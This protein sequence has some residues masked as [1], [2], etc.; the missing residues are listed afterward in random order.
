[1]LVTEPEFV[2]VPMPDSEGP[3]YGGQFSRIR[4]REKV[5]M[6]EEPVQL[7][8]TGR[9]TSVFPPPRAARVNCPVTGRCAPRVLEAELGSEL[10]TGGLDP[11]SSS[12][13]DSLVTADCFPAQL[14]LK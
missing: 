6:R 13:S 10:E 1:M 4:E 8:R 5:C 14:P 11:G 7:A 9:A 3:F 12:A 2:T